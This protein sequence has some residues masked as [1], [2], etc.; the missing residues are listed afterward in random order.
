MLVR[1]LRPRSVRCGSWRRTSAS[2]RP[3]AAASTNGLEPQIKTMLGGS[4]SRATD[5]PSSR[6]RPGA[7]SRRTPGGSRVSVRAR[8]KPSFAA[9]SAEQFV[10]KDHLVPDRARGEQT[11]RGT[12]ESAPRGGAAS[13]SAARRPNRRRPEAAGRHLSTDQTKCPPSGPRS[14]ISS[15]TCATS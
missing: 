1:A 13:P 12:P 14:S 4:G 10:A 15:P 6:H 9:S 8:S 3:W 2:I 5:R 11:E 7:E